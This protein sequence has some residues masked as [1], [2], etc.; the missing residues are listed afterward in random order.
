MSRRRINIDSN[1]IPN[2]GTK[3]GSFSVENH[4]YDDG[5]I[6]T[7]SF[8]PLWTGVREAW[9]ILEAYPPPTGLVGAFYFHDLLPYNWS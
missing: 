8:I 9:D 4:P 1:V 2:A 5:T 7:L 6:G 3:S